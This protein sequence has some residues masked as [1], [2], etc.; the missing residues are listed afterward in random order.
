MKAEKKLNQ[1]QEKP[2]SQSDDLTVEKVQSMVNDIIAEDDG[3]ADRQQKFFN[4]LK[5]LRLPIDSA[6][7]HARR[8]SW[9]EMFDRVQNWIQKKR[10]EKADQRAEKIA[11]AAKLSAFAATCSLLFSIYIWYQSDKISKP[12]RR[13]ILSLRKAIPTHTEIA[14][15]NKLQIDLNLQ[16][17]NIGRNP[18][19]NLRFRSCYGPISDPNRL[20]LSENDLKCA[21]IVY[22]DSEYVPWEQL[23]IKAEALSQVYSL[24]LFYYC[25]LDYCDTFDNYRDYGQDFYCI[26]N[27]ARKQLQHATSEQKQQFQQKINELIRN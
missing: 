24:T 16:F 5:L 18:A 27:I 11:L 14:T 13:P 12:T 21:N 4:L 26:Y 6:D 15:E 3:D 8:L 23:T 9:P 20:R 19:G 22:P 10:D 7:V 1:K 2:K 17:M 25:R